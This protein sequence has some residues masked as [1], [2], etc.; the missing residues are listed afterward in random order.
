MEKTHKKQ[1]KM[2]TNYRV[3]KEKGEEKDDEE[4]R[5]RKTKQKSKSKSFNVLCHYCSSNL[6]DL[7]TVSCSRSLLRR[8]LQ[9]MPFGSPMAESRSRSRSPPP[10]AGSRSLPGARRLERGEY[11]WRPSR[12]PLGPGVLERGPLQ[13]PFSPVRAKYTMPMTP[14]PLTAAARPLMEI[15]HKPANLSWKKPIRNKIK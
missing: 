12:W 4:T 6:I 1:N 14:S 10:P 11:V 5:K 15:D 8:T 13:Y 3:R 9:T 2:M 7:A